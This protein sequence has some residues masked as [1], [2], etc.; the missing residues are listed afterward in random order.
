[1]TTTGKKVSNMKGKATVCVNCIE[2]HQLSFE[3]DSTVGTSMYSFG[4]AEDPCAICGLNVLDTLAPTVLDGEKPLNTDVKSRRNDPFES[5]AVVIDESWKNTTPMINS[6]GTVEKSLRDGVT[7]VE[8][9][10]TA[11]RELLIDINPQQNNADS[12]RKEVSEFLEH[13]GF[14]V[15]VEE[16]ESFITLSAKL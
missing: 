16:N 2:R 11:T 7:F 1:M 12:T 3:E 14:D 15:T 4:K 10:P 6:G 13:C 9:D 8:P 5:L